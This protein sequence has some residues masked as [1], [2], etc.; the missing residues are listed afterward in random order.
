MFGRFKGSFWTFGRG[1]TLDRGLLDSGLPVRRANAHAH[2]SLAIRHF[3][4]EAYVICRLC[5][6]CRSQS[7]KESHLRGA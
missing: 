3:A 6:Q 5:R 1:L 4:D 2:V 7:L